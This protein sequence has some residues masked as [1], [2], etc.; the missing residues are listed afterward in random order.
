MLTALLLLLRFAAADDTSLGHIGDAL[1][2]LSEQ[3]AE[4]SAELN[5]TLSQLVGKIDDSITVTESLSLDEF[6]I[7]IDK[8]EEELW[9]LEREIED[10]KAEIPLKVDVCEDAAS[11]K[12]CV[13]TAT[14]VWCPT[15]KSC[16][17]GDSAGPFDNE[18]SGFEYEHCSAADCSYYQYC[19]MCL[20]DSNCGWCLASSSCMEGSRYESGTCELGDFYQ[21][22]IESRNE[23]PASAPMSY[24]VSAKDSAEANTKV[25][26]EEDRDYQRMVYLKNS[27]VTQLEEETQDIEAQI[28]SLKDMEE[29]VRLRSNQA[30][31]IEVTGDTAESQLGTL[32]TDTDEQYSQ[33]RSEMHQYLSDTVTSSTDSEEATIVSKVQGET[34]SVTAAQQNTESTLSQELSEMDS[35]NGAALESILGAEEAIEGVSSEDVKKVQ[36]NNEELEKVDSKLTSKGYEFL[37]FRSFLRESS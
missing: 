18:C 19:D 27:R 9:Y 24:K 31:D 5:S 4:L 3:V 23:C 7:E 6:E 12:E 14:C 37:A 35:S 29:Q 16:V 33:E 28:R 2:A 22:F 26:D 15:L 1:Q 17:P 10:L 11:C 21:Q 36:A 8:A 25:E 30:R 20:E 34:D 32:G 13:D